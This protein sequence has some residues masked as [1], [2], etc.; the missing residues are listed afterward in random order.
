RCATIHTNASNDGWRA[1]L[2]TQQF[3]KRIAWGHW[4]TVKL[5]SSNQ[6]ELLDILLT[7]K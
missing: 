5:T 4:K 6:S 2:K 1:T 7:M 3:E